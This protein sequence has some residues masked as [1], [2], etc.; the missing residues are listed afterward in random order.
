LRR[1][2]PHSLALALTLAVPI[3]AQQHDHHISGPALA[4]VVRFDTSCRAIVAAV[5]DRGVHQLHTLSFDDA[6]GHFR[7]AAHSDVDCAMAYW[8]TAMAHWGRFARIGAS[9]ALAEGWRALDQAALV[10]RTP[11]V[12][13]RRYLAAMQ[14]RYRRRLTTGSVS[15]ASAMADLAAAYPADPHAPLFAAQ[16]RLEQPAATAAA[17][18]AAGRAALALLAA[19]AVPTRHLTTLLHAL[20]AGDQPLL[21][22]DVLP[23]A[24][25]VMASAEA[26][27]EAQLAAARVFERL[28]L[29]E[30]VAAAS[31]RAADAARANAEP[32][33]ELLA[34]DLR[35]YGAL[36]QGNGDAARMVSRRLDAGYL[37]DAPGADAQWLRAAVRARVALE[38]GDW[39]QAAALAMGGADDAPQA[40]PV[41]FARSIGAARLGRALDAEAAATRLGTLP[42]SADEGAAVAAVMTD[43]AVAWAAFATGRSDAA[44]AAMAAAAD[45]QDDLPA[46]G[47]W[48]RPLVPAREQL[49]ELLL[50]A[51]R[52]REAAA[53]FAAVLHRFPGRAGARTGL[54]A[55]V[56]TG[57]H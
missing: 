10:R 41:Y 14:G 7:L 42:R 53:A 23:E 19:P 35:V 2:A 3:G 9:D 16:A 56:K 22:G 40:A 27:A 6:L 57:G 33:A 39:H 29:W 50:A 34:L 54:S 18:L 48:R 21:A 31:Q 30:E 55:S 52:R 4:D 12:R 37:E 17:A 20:R 26:S 25:A 44:I 15:Y 11:T 36:Q 28:G 13:E 45:R 47:V 32:E 8:G 49:G 24:R 5:L 43:V 38:L 46:R 1:I 51:G